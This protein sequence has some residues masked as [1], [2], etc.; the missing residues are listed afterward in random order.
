[1][2]GPGA[3]LPILLTELSVNHRFPSGPAVIPNGPL[4]DVSP[5]ENS[6]IVPEVVIRPIR[7][8]DPSVNQRLPSAPAVIPPLPSAVG[9]E[10]SLIVL[11]ELIR[12]ISSTDPLY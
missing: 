3:I 7:L 1:M 9:I 2:F 8:A 10:N 5:L 4:A 11:E 12:P 6:V